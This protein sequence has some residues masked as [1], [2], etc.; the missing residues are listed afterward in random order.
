MSLDGPFKL[1]IVIILLWLAG[2][3]LLGDT[4]PIGFALLIPGLC[5]L[6]LCLRSART[7]NWGAVA[8]WAAFSLAV[9]A[10]EGL[11]ALANVHLHEFTGLGSNCD[12]IAQTCGPQMGQG[13]VHS[14]PLLSFLAAGIVTLRLIRAARGRDDSLR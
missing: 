6:A 10:C 12:A 8:A 5:L 11:I 3:A 7:E 4:W 13:I 14:L 2:V 1:L 9:L